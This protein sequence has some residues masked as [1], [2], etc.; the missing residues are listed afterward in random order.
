MSRKILANQRLL[1]FSWVDPWCYWVRALVFVRHEGTQGAVFSGWLI[2]VF[3]FFYTAYRS[4]SP[5]GIR[6]KCPFC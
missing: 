6:C 2:R 4:S 5:I 1:F 3:F